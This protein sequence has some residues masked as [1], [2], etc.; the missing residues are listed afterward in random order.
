VLPI[1][2]RV[3]RRSR[4]QTARSESTAREGAASRG[5]PRRRYVRSVVGSRPGGPALTAQ[6]PDSH[7]VQTAHVNVR[8][9]VGVFGLL[10]SGNLGNDASLEAVLSYLRTEQPEAA[11]DLMCSGPEQVTSQFGLPAA[12]L[13]WPRPWPWHQHERRAHSGMSSFAL[14]SLDI[15]LGIVVDAL[16]T[17]SWVRR[18]DVVIVPG[19]GILETTL[20]MRPWETPYS[21]FLLCASG[22]LFGTKVALVS[23][24]ASLINKKLTRW[25]L[26]TAARLAHF[27]SFRD[28]SSRDAMRQ[29]GVGSLRDEVVPDL[30]FSLPN[31]PD[32][33]SS[34]GSIGV[35]V[36]AYY[37]GN[38]D[39]RW[40]QD[41]HEAYVEKMKCFVRRLLDSGRSVRLITG[42]PADEVVVAE[43]IADLSG[44]RPRPESMS[45]IAEPPRSL[46]DLMRQLAS[47]DFVVATRFHNVLC[48]L[49]MGIPTVSIGY[50]AKHEML[51][52]QMGVPEFC[53]SVHD[54]DIGLL[55]DQFASLEENRE[56]V[57]QIL[58]ERSIANRRLVEQHFATLSAVLFPVS[59]PGYR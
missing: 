21:V 20:P 47:V 26:T 29:M 39:R 27:R 8:P 50:S 34:R 54:L 23:V 11:V 6:L 56:Q 30:A 49:K 12:H 13:H 38:D 4:F 19:M 32:D 9:R 46:D 37:G 31:S 58:A 2:G 33:A 59:A 45:L 43:I 55:A 1:S 52:A 24:G 53:Q 3:D 22:R 36:M 10:G 7:G 42:D 18:H 17:A 51:M 28:D 15:G 41:I 57:R 16:R 14:K 44:D 5:R 40:A 25:L 35:G 48:A